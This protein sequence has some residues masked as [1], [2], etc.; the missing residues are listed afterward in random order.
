[1][2]KP[3]K[4][5]K[6]RKLSSIIIASGVV[7]AIFIV[8]VRTFILQMQDSIYPSGVLNTEIMN[9]FT[10]TQNTFGKLSDI[11]A[12]MEE[13]G[14]KIY[15]VKGYETMD[16]SA[17]VMAI[18]KSNQGGIL[19]MAKGTG[20]V[21][22]DIETYLPYY[23]EFVGK[24]SGSLVEKNHES[25][26]E[27]GFMAEYATGYIE[28]KN[29]FYKDN[30]YVAAIEY[31]FTP[32]LQVCI[33]FSADSLSKLEGGVESIKAF[34]AAAV[35]TAPE[36][37]FTD[38]EQKDAEAES[39]QGIIT[40]QDESEL[41]EESYEMNISATE[42]F[43][44]FASEYVKSGGLGNGEPVRIEKGNISM[45]ECSATV[46]RPSERIIF[47]FSHIDGNP[48]QV[49]LLAPDG[50]TYYTPDRYIEEDKTYLFYLEN[51]QTGMWRAAIS[52]EE[53]KEYAFLTYYEISKEE[54]AVFSRAVGEDIKDILKEENSGILENEPD[55]AIEIEME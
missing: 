5:K 46:S 47:S 42:S 32:D 12:I 35:S 23:E 28:V 52:L 38:I 6:E 17:D 20:N 37:E 18:V 2:S 51:P 1:M 14:L 39:V 26:T 21:V 48:L 15:P 8:V 30:I 45:V 11:A 3:S 44:D 36:D 41:T 50:Q 16:T 25:G 19:V 22:S 13:K 9:G 27:N 54:A 29:L 55:T 7:F 33:I 4:R 10:R 34:A 53:S 43:D 40:E 24:V 49:I 31:T